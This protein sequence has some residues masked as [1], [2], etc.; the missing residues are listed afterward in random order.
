M[1]V[2]SSED[3][4][5]IPRASVE[6]ILCSLEAASSLLAE[7]VAFVP[8]YRQREPA[9]ETVVA[10]DLD[11][12]EEAEEEE[13]RKGKHVGKDTRKG[14]SKGKPR[15]VSRSRSRDRRG[16]SKGGTCG[17]RSRVAEL[18][19]VRPV[20]ERAVSTRRPTQVYQPRL[21]FRTV[22]EPPAGL[23]N[24][25]DLLAALDD[26]LVNPLMA[27]LWAHAA[28]CPF[29]SYDEETV[30]HPDRLSWK[31]RSHLQCMKHV[32]CYGDPGND[33]MFASWIALTLRAGIAKP[34][35]QLCSSCSASELPWPACAEAGPKA[36]AF[37][38][39]K[40][41]ARH[42][43]LCASSAMVLLAGYTARTRVC[44]RNTHS[45]HLRWMANA[46]AGASFC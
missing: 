38:M 39:P 6:A 22:E 15:D 45:G 5:L 27:V 3:Q 10:E 17:T 7:G 25:G 19:Q 28:R 16:Q 26:L 41:L 9:D 46:S 33:N 13:P 44:W 1:P 8:Q 2:V 20:A 34:K 42:R 24:A 21:G 29:R 30:E 11:G 18:G 40:L 35:G 32:A 31:A 12:Q 14:R 36:V 43:N 4:V 23:A 37:A